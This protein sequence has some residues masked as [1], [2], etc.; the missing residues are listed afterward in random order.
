M[1][2]TKTKGRQ[3]STSKDAIRKRE[4]RARATKPPATDTPAAE[5]EQPVS[6]PSSVRQSDERGVFSRTVPLIV[7]RHSFGE[8]R[9]ASLNNVEVKKGDDEK[10]ADKKLLS[11][12]KRLIDCAEVKA[13]TQHDKV[14]SI[15]LRSVAAPYRP[16]M[17]LVPLG[18]VEHLDQRAREW[19]AKREEL[20]EVAARAYPARVEAMRGPLGPM[21]RRDDYP[22]QDEFRRAY[23]VSWRFVDFGA[24]ALLQTVKAEVFARE[25]QKVERE[26]QRAAELIRQHLRQTL[27]DMT[28]HLAS[29]LVPKDGKFPALRGGALDRL[30]EFVGSINLRDVTNDVDLRS[31]VRRLD[32]IGKGL[33]FEQLRDDEALRVATGAIV[34]EAQAVLATLVSDSP[35]AI[36]LR[37]EAE[38]A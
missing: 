34:Q 32:G 38:V 10:E 27:L 28:Q 7:E 12:T 35:R 33:T 26:A 21:W 3:L 22:P 30:L 1:T 36:R 11:L 29:L 18:M 15:Y 31:V 8:F 2:T 4:A 6:V 9:K 13:I 24:P 5:P 25:R 16:G 19:E 17:F 14:F 20:V 23:W 37:D